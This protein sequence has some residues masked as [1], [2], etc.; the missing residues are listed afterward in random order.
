MSEEILPESWIECRLGEVI[1]YGKTAKAEPSEIPEDAWILELEDIE[2][3]SG[4]LLSRVSFGERQS[5][6]TKN[7]FDKGD[8]LYGKLRPYLNKVVMAD[9]PG[10]CTTEIVPLR[11][12]EAVNSRYLL[13]WLRHPRFADYTSQVSH[14][15]SMPRLG[16]EAGLKAPFV[17]APFPEQQRIA[18]KLDSLL[19]RVDA[20]REHLDRVPHLLKHL[21]ESMLT[22]ATRNAIGTQDDQEGKAELVQVPLRTALVEVRTGPF[23][24]ALH[25]SDYVHDGIPVVNP[26][27]INAG[28]IEPS[29]STTISSEKA[30]ELSDFLLRAGDVVIARRGVMGRCA[31]VQ[32]EQHG[33][34]CGTG[35]M[36]LRPAECLLADYLQIFL[37]SPATVAELEAGAVGSTM[38][39]LNQGILLQLQIV[40]PSLDKQLRNVK[41]VRSLQEACDRIGFRYQTARILVDS[42]TPSLLAKAFRGELAPQDPNDEPASVLLERIKAEKSVQPKVPKT[43]KTRTTPMAKLTPESLLQVIEALPN[44][45][46]SFED[47][48]SKVTGDFDDVS[49]AV[50]AL[51]DGDKLA[52][53]FDEEAQAVRLERTA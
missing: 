51:L 50:F 34:L 26:M 41:A 28:K 52:Q 37:S 25:K 43:R 4:R 1:P 38:V 36:I 39:N 8:V 19:G 49:R 10:F 18:D 31:V 33:W 17:L 20:C 40:L 35:S 53:V 42:M 3:D 21:R 27:H 6:S 14:G 2:K 22:A 45:R 44:D 32:P 9:Q 30:S 48:R 46:F 24:S 5:K 16:T 11:G 15:L 29:S 47:L 12:N 13:H 23:G 7:R